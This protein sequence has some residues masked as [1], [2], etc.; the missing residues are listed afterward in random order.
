M[1]LSLGRMVLLVNDYDE[2]FAFYE[3]NFFCRRLFDAEGEDG[4]R[5]LHMAFPGDQVHGIWLMKP[6]AEPQ[7]QL[8]GAQTGGQP[9]MVLYTRGIAELEQRLRQN[10]VHISLSLRQTGESSFFH[11]ADLY[12]NRIT[13]V[14]LHG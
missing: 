14:E 11:C 7:Q 2:A 1:E 5:Y 4:R 6:E 13:V 8:V 12:G 3:K 9:A 10:G